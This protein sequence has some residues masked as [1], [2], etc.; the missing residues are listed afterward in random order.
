MR[1]TPMRHTP[2]RYAPM[3]CMSWDDAEKFLIY[4]QVSPM[5]HCIGDALG[6]IFGAKSSAKGVSDPWVAHD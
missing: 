2:A 1:C 4:P 5:S 6:V 3:R